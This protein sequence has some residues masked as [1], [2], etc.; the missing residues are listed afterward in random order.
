MGEQKE[1]WLTTA[2]WLKV[3]NETQQIKEQDSFYLQCN[4]QQE[5]HMV[6][7]SATKAHRTRWAQMVPGQAVLLQPGSPESMAHL[8]QGAVN[9]AKGAVVRW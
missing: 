8:L 5:H 1:D 4:K 7:F 9:K 2:Q 6:C 3:D